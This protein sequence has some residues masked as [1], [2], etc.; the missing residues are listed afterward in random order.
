MFY[1][2]A[3][4]LK[5]ANKQ[6]DQ[7]PSHSPPGG[8]RAARLGGEWPAVGSTYQESN[9]VVAWRDIHARPRPHSPVSQRCRLVTQSVYRMELMT[10]VAFQ[11]KRDRLH[12][13]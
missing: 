10:P 2:V 4:N 11:A 12:E 13:M 9:C 3:A 1:E 5:R 7:Q 8:F 6:I